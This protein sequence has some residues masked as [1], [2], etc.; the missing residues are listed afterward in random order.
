A[1][2]VKPSGSLATPPPTAQAED[3]TQ[4]CV[5]VEST[6][7]AMLS[8]LHL[9]YQRLL[10]HSARQNN[11]LCPCIA[12]QCQNERVHDRACVKMRERHM[13][14]R[15]ACASRYRHDPRARDSGHIRGF[16]ANVG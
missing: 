11:P 13:P 2:S 3:K 7:S 14:V 15:H 10:W 6:L 5:A 4:S 8:T 1:C 16:F 12:R 9:S